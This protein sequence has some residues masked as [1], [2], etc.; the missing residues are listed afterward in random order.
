VPWAM[1]SII[2]KPF[3]TYWKEAWSNTIRQ[4]KTSN[5]Q[6]PYMTTSVGKII[7]NKINEPLKPRQ[8]EYQHLRENA[9]D[10]V[11]WNA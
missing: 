1:E 11:L 10:E 8:N 7:I 9:Q 4:K 3:K 6:C 2:I 5:Y